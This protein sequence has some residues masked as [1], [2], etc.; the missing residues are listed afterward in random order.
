VVGL[1][2][3]AQAAIDAEEAQKLEEKLRKAT[4]SLDDFLKQIRQMRRIG[5]FKDLL[6]MIPG[7]GSRFQQM[8]VD[9]S[10]LN[11]VEAVIQ[12]MTPAERIRPEIIDGGRR[13]RIA[14]GS[15][16]HPHDVSGLVK[17]FRQMRTMMKELADGSLAKT[18]IGLQDMPGMLAR[19]PTKVKQRSKRLK[20][21]RK[22]KKR[23]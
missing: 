14:I 7:W 18:G 13:R 5:P 1:V 9:D 22:G 2:E 23:R 6:A 16:T 17:Q 3:K 11:R 19:G 15:G 8:D 10:E 21:K 4:F 12:S 20:G